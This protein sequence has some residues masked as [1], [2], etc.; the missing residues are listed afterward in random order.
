MPVCQYV[1]LHNWIGTSICLSIYVPVRNSVSICLP[2][3]PTN[4]SKCWLGTSGSSDSSRRHRVTRLNSDSPE[5][6]NIKFSRSDAP[7]ALHV[8]VLAST[9]LRRLYLPTRGHRWEAWFV[10]KQ[11]N[12]SLKYVVSYPLSMTSGQS[13]IVSSNVNYDSRNV[14]YSILKCFV[15]LVKTMGTPK[16]QINISAKTI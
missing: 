12:K 13:Q 15:R 9:D 10:S 1:Y 16:Q 7:P 8:S 14:L 3:S 4:T 5:H 2:S 6:P 11:K